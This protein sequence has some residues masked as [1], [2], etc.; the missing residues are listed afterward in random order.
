MGDTRGETA[1]PY[2]RVL[3]HLLEGVEELGGDVAVDVA[4][5]GGQVHRHERLD[6]DH[7]VDGHHGGLGRADRQDG[8]LAARS[9]C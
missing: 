6:A 7:A 2:L 3:D 1:R 4:V 9:L 5:V 8:A